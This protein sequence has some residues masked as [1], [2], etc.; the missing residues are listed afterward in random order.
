MTLAHFVEVFLVAA[1][2]IVELRG[3]IPDAINRLDIP[4][5]LAFLVA[6]AGNL[7]PV[8]FLLLFL[9]PVSRLFARVRLFEKI[10]E[11]IFERSRRRGDI[12]ERYGSIGLVLFVAVP[13]PVTGAW[14]GSIVAFLLGMKVRHAF[15]AIALG[16]FIA[17]VIVTILT[18]LGWVGATIAGV[19]L[20]GLATARFWSMRRK[21]TSS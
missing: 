1:S 10:L 11:W 19:A 2:P 9:G 16:V 17:G 4:W 5:A 12:V 18:L 14:T 21:E 3:A 13:L 8:P 6:Y 7:L 15:P 20:A